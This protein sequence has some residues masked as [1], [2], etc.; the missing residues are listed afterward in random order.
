M[1]FNRVSVIE[2]A[3]TKG[4]TLL[5]YRWKVPYKEMK[6]ISWNRLDWNFITT[7]KLSASWF[8]TNN[9]HQQKGQLI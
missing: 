2:H 8:N 7:K 1:I 4:E 9:Q 3:G 6:P 5:S